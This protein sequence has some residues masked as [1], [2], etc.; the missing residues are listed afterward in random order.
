M[1]GMRNV[2]CCLGLFST[3]TARWDILSD[4]GVA[5]AETSPQPEPIEE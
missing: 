4:F 5:S 3:D 1:D 2:I